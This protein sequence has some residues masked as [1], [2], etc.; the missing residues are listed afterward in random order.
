LKSPSAQ[1]EDIRIAGSIAKQYTSTKGRTL[2]RLTLIASVPLPVVAVND[3]AQ[4]RC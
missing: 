1:A 4:E 2:T 3:R